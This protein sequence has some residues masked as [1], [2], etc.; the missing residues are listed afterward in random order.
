MTLQQIMQKLAAEKA[1]GSRFPVRVIFVDSI[2]QYNE[3]LHSLSQV[4]DKTLQL[5][6]FCAGPDHIPNF[7]KMLREIDKYE[8]KQILLLSVSEYLR[9]GIKR[10]LLADKAQ[11]PPLWQSLQKASS[12]T[13]IIIPMLSCRELWDRVIPEM[14]ERQQD[15][16]WILAAVPS[17]M[18]AVCLEV[19]SQ[20][21]LSVIPND[22]AVQGMR[23]WL[24]DW[25]EHISQSTGKRKIIT[26]LWNYAENATSSIETQV[27][28][29]VFEYIK[30]AVK[31]GNVLKKEWGAD[32]E[33]LSLL[34]ALKSGISITHAIEHLLNVRTFDPLSLL[35][36]WNIMISAQRWLVW[37]WYRINSEN[38]YY[39]YAIKH[40]PSHLDVV[41][42]LSY[43]I[44]DV[45]TRQPEWIAQRQKAMCALK[46]AEPSEEFF[47]RV[48]RL[49]LMETR[50]DLLT[51]LTH[52]EK[53]YAIKTISQWLR[54]DADINA[55]SACVVDKYPLLNQ[56]LT[57]SSDAYS[58]NLKDYYLWYKKY[59]VMNVFPDN[60][61]NK[62]QTVALDSFSSRYS[63]LKKIEDKD[64][65]VLWIDAMGAEWL[66]LLMECLKGCPL[67]NVVTAKVTQSI[68]PTET[69]Y[70][71]QWKSMDITYRK[72]DKL[73][74]LAHK[75]MPDDKNYFSCV[76]H[77]LNEIENVAK[78]AMSL[79]QEHDYVAITADHGTSRL[80]ALAF[81]NL[82][83][84]SAP[85]GAKVRSHGRYCILDGPSKFTDIVPGT[86]PVSNNNC[87]YLV[88]NT[89]EHYAQSGNAA[90]KYDVDNANIGEVHGGATPEEVLVPVIIL[91]RK[92]PL[93][94]LEASMLTP[95][96]YRD[97]GAVT[98]EIGFN[99]PVLKLSAITSGINGICSPGKDGTLW[100]L[101]FEGI[102]VQSYILQLEVEGKVLDLQQSFLVKA[103]GISQNDD[104]LGGL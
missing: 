92:N 14:G 85:S 31:D 83:G 30:S 2:Q 25:N 5:A 21:F 37:L 59:K 81:H 103:K 75:G 57:I 24:S 69:C 67:G 1:M 68:L 28:S 18:E 63:I 13:R 78:T 51:C 89:H 87:N 90:G 40:S 15:H 20:D 93:Q 38:D 74:I 45:A 80:A 97:K 36:K 7:R 72:L 91:K 3:L 17:G 95:T 47:K 12:K 58:S 33:W 26:S 94:K 48:D 53:T 96:V 49:P 10:E 16:A 55:V 8:G 66:P 64:A 100:S 102:G 46:I 19:Y 99:R 44:F 23:E 82:P 9:L 84:I 71:D 27:I 11:I 6:S 98:V 52:S 4:C 104:M 73:D 29:N 43:A 65:V 77:Q 42:R 35:A 32:A 56:Y 70:N 62:V 22:K 60:A 39:C 61:E 50:L 76:A 86:L 79:L 41:E 88:F 101:L 54:K 34:P